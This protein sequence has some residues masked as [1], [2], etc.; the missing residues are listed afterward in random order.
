[1][2]R[3]IL[4]WICSTMTDATSAIILTHN[5]DFL[6]LQSIVRSRLRKCGHPK[7]TVFADAACASNSYRQQHLLLDGLGRQYRVVQVD[8]GVGRRFHPKAILLA[9]PSKAALAVGS[10]NLTH[11]GWSANFEVW[12]SYETD[13]DGLPAIS[14]FR[15]Y[16]QTV[17]SLVSQSEA[18]SGEVS[19]AFDEAVNP[20][21]GDLPEPE[22]L[23]GVPGDRPLLDAIAQIVGD[24]VTRVTVCTPYY[25]PDGEA[26]AEFSRRFPAPI[27]TLLQR[28]Y[29]GL[30]AGAASALR[31]NVALHSVD[32][33]PSRFV[34][35][36]WFAFDRPESTLLVAGSANMSRAA[37]MGN[38]AWGNAELIATQS[39][40]AEQTKELLDDFIFLEERPTLPDTPPSEGWEIQTTPVRILAAS[41]ANG[42]LNIIFK[43]NGE[44]AFP[45]VELEDGA[46]QTCSYVP[47][48]S[49][50]RLRLS[51]CP[52][53]VRLHCTLKN[54]DLLSSEPSWVD[55]EH[56]LGISVPERRIAAKLSEAME[57]GFLSANGMF[58]IL[59]LLQQ[60][61]QQ[62]SRQPSPSRPQDDDTVDSV[63]SYSIDDVFSDSFGRPRGVPLAPL[64]GG[65]RETDFLRAF[66]AYFT[67]GDIENSDEGDE[68]LAEPQTDEETAPGQEPEE[69]GDDRAKAELE[70]HQAR[71]RRSEV[72]ARLRR[73][74]IA[75][76][77]KVVAAMSTDEFVSS[78]SPERLAADIAATALLV[79]KGLADEIISGDDFVAISN[80]LWGVLFF[81]SEGEHGV[82]QSHLTMCSPE[83]RIKFEAAF[84]SARLTAALTLWCLPNWGGSGT[85]A[86]R[87]RFSAMLLTARL[88]WLVAG[89]SI[90]EIHGEF[91][92]LARAMP[93]AA[94]FEALVAAWTR[95]I[96]AGMAFQEF[97]RA[98]LAW[99]PRQLAQA[100][101]QNQVNPGE[102]LW[103][104][105]KFCV[106]HG[107][108]RR[109][110]ST[111]AIVYPLTEATP[112]RFKGDWLV[113]VSELLN[114]ST[115]VDVADGVK[116]TMRNILLDV[117]NM[118]VEQI[119]RS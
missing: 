34:H 56:S 57:A 49:L 17:S 50:A 80:R 107:Y 88:P 110:Q 67:I 46:L 40:S 94:K 116:E 108:Y 36:K 115:L 98:L 68:P 112:I 25:D 77:E 69:I 54:G 19:A 37:L 55:D 117:E 95:W 66:S 105:G 14:A 42:A 10:G 101:N 92:R 87:F 114:H 12:A 63:Q 2:R 15:N 1:M 33:D 64:L 23:L 29:V 28:N 111:N 65:F 70:Q 45:M 78:R 32:V 109:D 62:P 71:L 8:M 90:E 44:V 5:I 52:K 48:D 84:A 21:V 59:Q 102:L 85:Q 82:L 53:S 16:L 27:S 9:G 7:L 4:E 74:L 73:R 83:D 61:L 30:S 43:C 41:F 26:L 103:Q 18:I 31:E 91:R 79:R 22:G 99:S 58:E 81:G 6:F 11:G 104:G 39:L 51:K 96:R 113:P 24:N 35:A 119:P 72:S 86:I 76:L 20:W 13:D 38:T 60:H 100:I 89:A 75:A 106:A 97:E 47:H 3:N 93:N 118:G